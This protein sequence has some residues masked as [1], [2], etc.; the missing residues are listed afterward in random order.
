[1]DGNPDANY[2]MIQRFLDNNDPRE[3]LHRLFN[4]DTQFIIGDP[5][6]IHRLSAK[7]TKYVGKIGKG[8][9]LGFWMLTLSSPY[10]GRAIPFNFITYSSKTI[11]REYI[12]ISLSK[13]GKI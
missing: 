1:M 2:K 6:E 4:E 5:T 8:K 13:E 7:K 3:N 9:K 10:K 12:F 11:K